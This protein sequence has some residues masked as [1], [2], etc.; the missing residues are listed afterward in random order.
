[1]NQK[2]KRLIFL[3]QKELILYLSPF[4][5]AIIRPSE[6]PVRNSV[7]EYRVKKIECLYLYIS[8]DTCIRVH[9]ISYG[10]TTFCYSEE[11][12]SRRSNLPQFSREI[13]SAKSAL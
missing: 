12:F 2:K 7:P 3:A 5:F 1:M 6:V 8:K 11:R 13:A 10:N 4:C 9:V